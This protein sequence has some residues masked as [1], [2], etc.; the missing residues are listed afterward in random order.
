[1]VYL[2][3]DGTGFC[4]ERSYKTLEAI[5]IMLCTFSKFITRLTNTYM[6]HKFFDFDLSHW[7]LFLPVHLREKPRMSCRLG[8]PECFCRPKTGYAVGDFRHV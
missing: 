8:R 7:V 3:L 5:M 6:Q 2:A 1:M 4:P